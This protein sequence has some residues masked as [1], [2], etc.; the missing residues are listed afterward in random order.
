MTNP[1]LRLRLCQDYSLLERFLL[2]VEHLMITPGNILYH[3]VSLP[4][5][6]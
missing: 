3:N 5:R 1:R 2:I 4:V 6:W